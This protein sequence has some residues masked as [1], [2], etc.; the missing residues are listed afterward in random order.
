MASNINVKA[1]RFDCDLIMARLAIRSIDRG[2]GRVPMLVRES[3]RGYA[4]T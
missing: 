2:G 4:I 3:R 1:A